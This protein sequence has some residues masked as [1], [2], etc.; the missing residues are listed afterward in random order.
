[1]RKV[2]C[3]KEHAAPVRRGNKVE[4]EEEG[5]CYNNCGMGVQ[6]PSRQPRRE[7]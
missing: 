6:V 4:L 7:E 5:V 3:R 1:M 2:G